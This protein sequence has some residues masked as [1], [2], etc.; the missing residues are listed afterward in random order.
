MGRVFSYHDTHLHRIGTSYEQLPINAATS[1]V[2]SYN[3]DG[4]MTY[5]HAGSQ[6][7]YAPNSHGGPR[8]DP[9]NELPTWQVEA[10][11]LGRYAYRRHAADDDFVQASALYRDVMNDTERANLAANIIG[12]AGDGVTADTQRRVVDYWSSVDP[13]LGARVATGL[14]VP[15]PARAAA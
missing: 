8:A 10:A 1:P 7:V 5:R 14:G 6:P 12:H 4:H 15:Q 2:R 9:G 3:K 11:E 13:E